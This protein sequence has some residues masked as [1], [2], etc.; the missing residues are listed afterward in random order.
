M[1]RKPR[2]AK[3]SAASGGGA[4]TTDAAPAVAVPPYWPIIYIRGY[5]ATSN[6]IEDAVE[7]PFMGFDAGSTKV[8]MAAD[9]SVTRFIFESP[10]VRLMKDHGY[11]DAYRNGGYPS[12][13]DYDDDRKRRPGR[14]SLWV[15]RYYDLASEAFGRGKRLSIE[16][17]AHM[18]RALILHVR[19]AVCDR[20]PA[21][22]AAFKVYLVAHSMGGLIARCY[23]Q[24]LCAGKLID[25]GDNAEDRNKAS[26]SDQ[27]D[28]LR[29]FLQPGTPPTASLE[30]A[31]ELPTQPDRTVPHYVDKFFTYGTPHGGIEVLGLNVPDLGNFSIYH[32]N[33]FNRDRM[34]QFLGI[35]GEGDVR[36]LGGALDPARAFCFIGTNHRDYPAFGG[37]AKLV[38]GV[39][40]D[41]LVMCD[42][43][44]V[45]GAAQAYA[46]RSH[47]GPFGIVN[48]E[49]G[50]QNLQRFLFGTHR[51][52]VRLRLSGLRLPRAVEQTMQQNGIPLDRIDGTL[53]VES[54][55]RVRGSQIYLHERRVVHGSAQLR[56]LR[57]CL[58]EEKAEET[59][60]FYL[61]SG[62][63]DLKRRQAVTSDPQ[64]RE[65]LPADYL[66]WVESMVFAV[67][68]GVQ[69]PEVR[70]DK[71]WW[72]D[73]HIEGG[74]LLREDL[75][76]QIADPTAAVPT[77]RG[78][79]LG[80]GGS[81]DELTELATWPTADGGLALTYDVGQQPADG[82]SPRAGAAWGTLHITIH[83][84]A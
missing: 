8:R 46:H 44:F 55:V 10:L 47:S 56:K 32:A 5:A 7:Q 20:D 18:L 51:V 45:N 39:R 62:F 1:A 79:R 14:Q 81:S 34:R 27:L 70:I 58:S 4:P 63:L 83:R 26:E 16:F 66:N 12:L 43:A 77:L 69:L 68:L 67:E 64:R 41:G 52:D 21:A 75:M 24:A 84:V 3:G 50:Y 9:L 61:F 35:A 42:N 76:F 23:L 59:L 80:Q 17:Y 15:M 11:R 48:S 49:E 65:V 74:T 60:S 28:A 33:T 73:E 71:R 57:D 40:S 13:A 38:S 31:L 25:Y 37:L 78:G 2:R 54:A 30:E 22:K 82:K 6:Q 53:Q 72:F 29:S 36:E 19:D